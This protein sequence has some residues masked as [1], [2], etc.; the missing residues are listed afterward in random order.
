[1]V[2]LAAQLKSRIRILLRYSDAVPDEDR[3]LLEDRMDNVAD[4]YTATE[5]ENRVIRCES[6]DLNTIEGDLTTGGTGATPTIRSKRILLGDV[7]R[8]DANYTTA[9]LR[10]RQ[11]VFIYETTQLALILGVPNY[12]NPAWWGNRSMHMGGRIPRVPAPVDT[13]V[14]LALGTD[15]YLYYA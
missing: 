6:A 12:A 8:T 10:E 14:N 2:V 9:S 3:A 13:I 4:S 1:M 7:N 5:I 15:L 11:D